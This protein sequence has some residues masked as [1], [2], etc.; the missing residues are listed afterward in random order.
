[1]QF[2]WENCGLP[3]AHARME[4]IRGP[5]PD[6]EA[7]KPRSRLA[8]ER[9]T[10]GKRRWR[11]VADDEHEFGVDLTEP[12]PDGAVFYVNEKAAY[13]IAQ[14]YEP[15]LELSVAASSLREGTRAARL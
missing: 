10:L 14:K 6:A 4:L 12:L 3:V 8:V 11:G 2:A 15:V 13:V 9:L 5:I 1:M 7:T